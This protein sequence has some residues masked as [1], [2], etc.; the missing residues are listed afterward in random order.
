MTRNCWAEAKALKE[1]QGRAER[2][3]L[4]AFPLP[5]PL[6]HPLPSRR[7]TKSRL[8]AKLLL[9]ILITVDCRSPADQSGRENGGRAEGRGV[10]VGGELG[11]IEMVVE[12]PWTRHRL[13]RPH[14]TL[15]P[16]VIS[17]TFHQN[18]ALIPAGNVVVLFANVRILC[19]FFLFRRENLAKN[20]VKLRSNWRVY[21]SC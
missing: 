10:P 16:V 18:S 7:K 20:R 8:S 17:G 1:G 15:L 5:L 2:R 21:P 6:H 12:E 4:G 13:W 3:K 14:R 9:T 11:P 19:R